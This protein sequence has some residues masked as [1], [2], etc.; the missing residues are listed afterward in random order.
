MPEMEIDLEAAL[1]VIEEKINARHAPKDLAPELRRLT[2]AIPDDSPLR[3]RV[4]R[5][6]GIVFNRLKDPKRA[7]EHL[8]L[9]RQAAI[10]QQNLAEIVQAGRE[11]AVVHAWRGE[12][13]DAALALLRAVAVAYLGNDHAA[14]A[15]A[16]SEA[17]R[18]ELEARRFDEAAG[19]FRLVADMEP[20]WLEAYQ[21][22]RVRINLCQ[23][24]NRL[25]RH[26]EVLELAASLAGDLAK[27]EQEDQPDR[28]RRLVFLT[29][30]EEA[31]AHAGLRKLD[32]ATGALERARAL[33]PED[34]NEFEHDEYRE[35]EAEIKLARE[36]W[37]AIED[38]KR[39]AKRYTDPSLTVRAANLRLMAGRVL[40]KTGQAGEAGK[41]LADALRDAVKAGLPDL[42][43]RIRGEMLEGEGAKHLDAVL[44]DTG[45]IEAI[46]GEWSIGRQLIRVDT[47][48]EGGGGKVYRAIDLRDGQE[49]AVKEVS[50]DTHDEE[51][52]KKIIELVRNEYAVAVTLPEHPGI[53]KVRGLLSDPDGK[54]YI[55]QDLVKGSSLT[56]LYAPEPVPAK[57]LPLLIDV[58]EA[59]AMLHAN[60]IV[61]RDLKPDNVM[62]RRG[63]QR[64]EAVL[65]DFGIALLDGQADTLKYYGTA[66]YMAPEQ[67]RGDGKVGGSADIYS[68]GKMIAEVW[69][70]E[71]R[72]NAMPKAL[73]MV[74]NADAG[75]RARKAA[76]ARRRQVCAPGMLR[77]AEGLT[78]LRVL[79][80]GRCRGGVG[81]RR[82]PPEVCPNDRRRAR[83]RP[84]ARSSSTRR[85]RLGSSPSPSPKPSAPAPVR[86]SCAGL[87]RL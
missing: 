5:L 20:Q 32:A 21:V 70:S 31:R 41:L 4:L 12:D 44:Q 75:D 59:L 43:Q 8:H 66:G 78:S 62:V 22:F 46:G 83:T 82:S 76:L 65:I 40:F 85:C 14:T 33:L 48:G 47:L 64:E 72:G 50:L 52:R 80:R 42:A 23:A 35:A 51:K 77:G 34:K 57:L 49:V 6:R 71:D 58:A 86:W 45:K 24:L 17:G 38:L 60:H 54:L 16:L 1:K 74:V 84:A 13:R 7:L 3:P 37:T 53:A 18:I 26:Q 30:L 56:K 67:A 55:V 73:A 9:A 81:G 39:L 61:H 28:K 87:S 29:L 15:L 63:R 79:L 19:L 2:D 27:P 68:L 11:I 25:E 69:G 10:A 36:D